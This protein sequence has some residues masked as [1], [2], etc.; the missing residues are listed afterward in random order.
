ME[1]VV[2]GA[3]A[4]GV[5]ALS[6]LLWDLPSNIP[7]TF[8]VVLHVSPLRQSHLPDI[9]AR[10][11]RLPAEHPLDGQKTK[12]GRIYVAPPDFHLILAEGVVRLVRAAKEHHTRPAIDP[13]FFSAAQTYGHRV[14]GVLLTGLLHDGVE[15]LKEIQR[16][17]GLV[18]V[19]DPA[20]AEFEDLPKNALAHVEVDAC[21]PVAQIRDL[22]MR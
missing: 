1:F 20:E 22:L 7:V 17:G 6:K 8:F 11:A 9:L 10:T 21:L 18:M 2:V 16:H 5:E 3:S 15:G 12:P 4:G 13:L 19:Q 14:V